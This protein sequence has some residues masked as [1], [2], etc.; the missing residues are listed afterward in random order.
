MPRQP[1]RRIV[2]KVLEHVG[3]AVPPRRD[4]PSDVVSVME[5]DEL[6]A[7]YMAVIADGDDNRPVT[8]L[9][10]NADMVILTM[11]MGGG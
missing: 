9:P 4:K 8:E 6:G 10:A 7:G 2:G 5:I 1:L 11:P 3:D